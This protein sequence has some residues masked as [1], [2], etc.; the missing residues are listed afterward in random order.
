MTISL[1][2]RYV[3]RQGCQSAKGSAVG[4]CGIVEGDFSFADEHKVVYRTPAMVGHLVVAPGGCVRNILDA[5]ISKGSASHHP[6]A[7]SEPQ[8][9]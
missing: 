4:A 5:M 7:W 1:A 8:V 6:N 2:D 9:M 3:G